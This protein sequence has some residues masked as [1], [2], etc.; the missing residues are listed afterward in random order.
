MN[1]LD[2][3][4]PNRCLSCNTIITGDGL[5]CEKCYSKVNFTHWE[6]LSPNPLEK[7]LALFFNIQHAYALMN[8]EKKGLSQKIIH[9]LKYG[10]RE[11]I[12]K[13]LAFWCYERIHLKPSI[14]YLVTVPL[15]PS[16][17]KK[18]GYNQLHLFA[19]TLS[20]LWNIPH[21]KN[22]LTRETFN[23]AQAQKD[24]VHR[25]QNKVQFQLNSEI[26]N[27][28]ILL[29]DDVCTTGGTLSSCAWE[30]IKNQNTVSVLV[31]AID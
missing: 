7:R 15:H 17:L 20:Q 29:I 25:E 14:D 10:K 9:Q 13:T 23:S 16:K 26:K 24:R 8:F 27:K 12:G 18:R 31:M 2:I 6:H 19:D 21:F 28:H 30:L 3:L 5:I 11:N 22:F 1:L 4:F